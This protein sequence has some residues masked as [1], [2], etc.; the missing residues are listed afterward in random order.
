MAFCANSRS[1]IRHASTAVAKIDDRLSG[2]DPRSLVALAILGKET[3]R[4]KPCSVGCPCR[5]E[6]QDAHKKACAGAPLTIPVC[7]QKLPP[8]DCGS[9]LS[10]AAF[11]RLREA[12]NRRHCQL[13]RRE[14]VLRDL[15]RDTA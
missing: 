14:A 9:P 4:R 8:Q 10:P 11:V 15:S 1:H 2:L 3:G 6:R 12:E 5:G 7:Y 13:P